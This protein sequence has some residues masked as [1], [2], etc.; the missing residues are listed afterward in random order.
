M[1]ITS[2]DYQRPVIA[3]SGD[4]GDD[5]QPPAIRVLRKT[6]RFAYRKNTTVFAWLFETWALSPRGDSL[7]FA[8]ARAA[9][10]F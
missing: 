9:R 6:S 8:P 3:V 7:L 2:C 10:L 4:S 5:E 1:I